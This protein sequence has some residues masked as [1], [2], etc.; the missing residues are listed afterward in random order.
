MTVKIVSAPAF[1]FDA[2]ATLT[3][4][5][6]PLKLLNNTVTIAPEATT[7]PGE[8]QLTFELLYPYRPFSIHAT[9]KITAS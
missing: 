8:G 5:G 4:K 1:T 2:Y 3:Y 7:S 6:T 9:V